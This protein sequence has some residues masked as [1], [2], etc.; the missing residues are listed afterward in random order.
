MAEAEAAGVGFTCD[1]RTKVEGLTEAL[2]KQDFKRLGERDL[3]N[4][5]AE[6]KSIH[7]EYWPVFLLFVSAG[8][9]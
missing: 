9:I 3:I 2:L 5:I 4:K 8:D 7:G 1:P 6:V